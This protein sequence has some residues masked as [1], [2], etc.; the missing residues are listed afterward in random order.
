MENLKIFSISRDSTIRVTQVYSRDQHVLRLQLCL[1]R[2]QTIFRQKIITFY[3]RVECLLLTLKYVYN[4]FCMDLFEEN[5]PKIL[6]INYFNQVLNQSI[7]QNFLWKKKNLKW[8]DNKWI[9]SQISKGEKIKFIYF[10]LIY[11]LLCWL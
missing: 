10:I 3:K 5:S 6:I 7:D 9:Y 4:Y 2:T 8:I 1:S 11:S